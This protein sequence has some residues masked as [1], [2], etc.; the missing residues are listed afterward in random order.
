MT[1]ICKHCISED[2]MPKTDFCIECNRLQLKLRNTKN[3]IIDKFRLEHL[4]RYRASFWKCKVVSNMD[5]EFLYNDLEKIMSVS[6]TPNYT[7]H[8]ANDFDQI[9][10]EAKKFI[11]QSL[12]RLLY[13]ITKNYTNVKYNS[14]FGNIKTDEASYEE[15]IKNNKV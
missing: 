7:W 13:Q 2:K 8:C 14:I 12:S 1:N 6:R 9:D 11:S 15:Y 5:L 10:K 4:L 3:K